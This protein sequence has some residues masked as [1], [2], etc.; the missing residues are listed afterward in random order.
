[1]ISHLSIPFP[2]FASILLACAVVQVGGIAQADVVDVW[3]GTTT[4][5]TGPSK[6]IYHA[7]FDT[8][9]G[10]LTAPQLA[11]EIDSPGFLT[12]HPTLPILYSVGSVDGEA[13]VVSFQIGDDANAT[14]TQLNAQ[15]V[16]DGGAAHLAVDHKGTALITAQYGGGSTAL[17]PLSAD[18]SIQ[19]RSQLEKHPAGSG[20]VANRQDKAHA[21]WTGFSPDNRFAFVPDLGLDQVVIWNF[22]T[23]NGKPKLT[24][25]G[26]GV[27]PPGSGPRHMKFSPD[28]DIVYVLNELSLTVTVFQYDPAA[29]TMTAIQTIPTL[30][31]AQKAKESFNSASEI[32][33]HPTGK[34]VY[35]ANRG[36]DSITVFSVDPET[37]KLTLVEQEPIRGGWP[38]NFNIDPSGKWL[39]AAGRDSHTASVFAIDPET[40]ELQYSRMMQ[41][42]PAPICVLFR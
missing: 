21:H 12:L 13:S 41:T 22:E 35:A 7:K 39:M 36:H 24:N 6:G 34:F 16:G 17:F 33:V 25:H 20:V 18:G 4:G 30:S 14:L 28:G 42:V 5:K 32:R 3:F 27:C 29:G 38:R 1:M 26:A 37:S 31:E 9:N 15:A 11:A 23:E 2:Y 19:P 10:R 40:G 8:D